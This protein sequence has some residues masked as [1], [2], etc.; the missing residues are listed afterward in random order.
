MPAGRHLTMKK[1]K[2][3]LVVYSS[4]VYRLKRHWFTFWVWKR[5]M[6]FPPHE[7][8]WGRPEAA[9]V[10]RQWRRALLFAAVSWVSDGANISQ[11]TLLVSVEPNCNKWSTTPAIPFQFEDKR[12]LL[13]SH[14][15]IWCTSDAQHIRG[16]SLNCAFCLNC[17]SAEVKVAL[18]RTHTRSFWE[19]IILKN[20]LFLFC[21][22]VFSVWA[23]Q[24]QLV[25]LFPFRYV[26]INLLSDLSSRRMTIWRIASLITNSWAMSWNSTWNWSSAGGCESTQQ[27][28]ICT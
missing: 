3:G 7:K 23:V 10:S 22:V 27:L 19:N 11:P 6:A 9:N 20:S 8:T 17:H 4:P 18:L 16:K 13:L 21:S 1:K 26:A 28:N 5:Q 24:Q 25:N 14:V 12:H 2:S 15:C